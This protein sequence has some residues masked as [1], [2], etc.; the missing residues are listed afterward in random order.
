MLLYRAFLQTLGAVVLLALALACHGKSG[1]SS[2]PAGTANITGTVT[3]SRVPLA[4]DAQGLP[5]GLVDATVPTNLKTLPARGVTVRFYQQLTQTDAA[6][7]TSLEWAFSGSSTTDVNGIYVATLN[8]GNPTMVELASTFDGG[9]G[10]VIHLIAEPQGINSST[11]VVSRLQYAQRKAANGTVATASI[12]APSSVLQANATVDFTIGLHDEWWLVNPEYSLVGNNKAPNVDQAQ[13][14]TSYPGR[15]P[16]DGT[17]SR[18]LGVGD[19]IASFRINYGS[20]TPGSILD[21]HYWPGRTEARGSFIEYDQSIYPLAFDSSNGIIHY[22]GSLS[23]GANDD[24]WDEGVIMPLLARNVLFASNSS[25]TFAIP[26][27]RLFPQTAAQ[28]DLSPDLARI[29]GL[30]EAMAANLLKSPYLADTQGTALATPLKDVRD[31]S[32][33]ST[34]QKSPYSAPALRAF[35]WEIVLKANSLPSPGTATNWATINPLATSRFFLAPSGGTNSASNIATFDSEPINIFSQIARLSETKSAAEPVDLATVLSSAVVATLGTPFGI[36]WPRPTS[37]PYASF[38]AYWGADPVTPFP[39]VPLS[40]AKAIQV[41]GSY[42]NYSRG[43]VCY[44]G[45]SLN[46]DK[47]CILSATIAPALVAGG[48]VDVDLPLMNQTFSFTG[49]GGSTPVITIPVP[50]TAPYYHPVRLRMKS[51]ATLQPDV[52]VTLNITPVP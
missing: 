19:T 25:R 22:F 35:A 43:E 12:N 49:T 34:A 30:A 27:N 29:E 41:N 48:Q 26:L 32:S 10:G 16:G 36:S 21:L 37:G 33:L 17:G 11:P 44:A 14:E 42:P 1:S 23:G 7:H 52:V 39:S 47:R 3:Y 31:I 9:N 5:T 15:T 18:V 8:L 24:A 13:L 45:F 28:P 4:V 38:A 40:M 46:A 2:Q 50:G 51:P 6:G 20:A